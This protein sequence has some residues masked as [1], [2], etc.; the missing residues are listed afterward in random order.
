MTAAFWLA[1][2]E[3][4]NRKSSFIT[5]VA[6]VAV[7]MALCTAVEL[8]L[9]ARESAVSAEIDHMGPAL[10]LIPAGQTAR[11]LARFDLGSNYLTKYEAA[12]IGREISSWIRA[13]EGR[14][15]LNEPLEGKKTLIAGIDPDEVVSPFEV[16]GRLGDNDAALGVNLAQRLGKKRGDKISFKGSGFRVAAVLPETAGPEDLALFLPIHRL[17]SLAGLPHVVNEIRLFPRSGAFIEKIISRLGSEH[18]QISIINTYRGDT[19]EH[20]IGISLREHRW[21]L[22]MITSAVIAFCVLIWSYLNASERSVEMATVVAIGGT[23]RVVLFMLVI[24]AAIVGIAGS[25]LGYFAGAAFV[26]AQDF[27]SA[28]SVVWSWKLFL[29]MSGG[30]LVLSILGALPISIFSA[31]REH[32]AALQE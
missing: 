22:Y 1:W 28:L 5:G 3:L 12:K 4:T 16:L 32:V 30:V 19:A 21:V 31:F 7:A 29:A 23:G 8:V 11:D 10:R 18:P 25:L 13:M 14:L 6:M 24:R 2:R 20:E 17:W 15:L 9:R 26:L 27:N